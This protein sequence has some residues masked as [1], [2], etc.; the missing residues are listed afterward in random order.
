MSIS[1]M[2]QQIYYQEKKKQNQE[3]N[4]YHEQ[5]SED[6]SLKS[7]QQE[8]R[9][10]MMNS[11]FNEH[12]KSRYD[13]TLYICDHDHKFYSFD[14]VDELREH[15]LE[16]HDVDTRF[17]IFKMQ[18][19]DTN[20]ARHAEKHVYNYVSSNSFDYTTVQIEI[21]DLKLS[22]CIDF[23]E[24]VNLL[25]RFVLFRNN[26][27]DIMHNALSIII[28]DVIE[29]QIINQVIK[30][31]V[32][33]NFNKI[34]LK[35][36]T[37]LMKNLFS[38]LIIINDALN[39]LDVNLQHDNNIIKIEI[40][41]VFLFYNNVDFTSYHY[42][43][44]S[45]RFNQHISKIT[46]KLKFRVNSLKFNAFISCFN[47]TSTASASINQRSFSSQYQLKCRRC[48][49][50]FDFNNQLHNHLINCRTREIVKSTHHRDF[51][52]S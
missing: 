29:R 38:E 39:R 28:I 47:S 15:V 22:F 16:Y 17:N 34:S 10:V 45:M 32:K 40:Q 9:N 36:T 19:R 6:I 3:K 2:S 33:L 41:E 25:N 30:L 46:M 14:N 8:F 52:D 7:F 27:Y 12:E 26:L 21:F 44:T 20:H 42:T 24:I 49:Q 31:D 13:L 51:I 37:Y 43:I 5:K 18:I 35:M 23:D 50:I 1:T 4:A 48:K 11:Y